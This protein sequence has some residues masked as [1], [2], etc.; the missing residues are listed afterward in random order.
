MLPEEPAVTQV[1]ESVLSPSIRPRNCVVIQENAL[2]VNV[3]GAAETG[4]LKS[5]KVSEGMESKQLLTLTI[6]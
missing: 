2:K 4:Q 6:P 5:L 3:H 1:K